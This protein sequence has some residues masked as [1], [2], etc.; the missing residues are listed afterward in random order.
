MS[1]DEKPKVVRKRKGRV[2]TCKDYDFPLT[3]EDVVTK[4]TNLEEICDN[5]KTLFASNEDKELREKVKGEE[6]IEEEELEENFEDDDE[7]EEN[8]DED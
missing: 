8:D 5:F 7:N 1:N 2:I 4:K 3:E 6:I